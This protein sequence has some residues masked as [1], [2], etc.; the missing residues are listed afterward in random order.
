MQKMKLNQP[1]L[2]LEPDWVE[3]WKVLLHGPDWQFQFLNSL[4]QMDVKK[5]IL[6][7]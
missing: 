6:D 1:F 3:N 5:K 4:Q 7:V 2:R